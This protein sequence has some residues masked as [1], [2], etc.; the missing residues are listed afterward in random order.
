[1]VHYQ[2][3]RVGVNVDFDFAKFTDQDYI[4]GVDQITDHVE[5]PNYVG[6][7]TKA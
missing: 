3:K 1:M 7:G 5:V 2:F 4:V 6:H